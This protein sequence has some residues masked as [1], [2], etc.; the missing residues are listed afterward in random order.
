MIFNQFLTNVA[1]SSLLNNP[2]T[3]EQI[4]WLKEKNE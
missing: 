4:W 3:N 2:K 1:F